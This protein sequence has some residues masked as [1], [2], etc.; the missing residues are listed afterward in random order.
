[1]VQPSDISGYFDILGGM[2]G[3]SIFQGIEYFLLIVLIFGGFA[4]VYYYISFPFKVTVF[5]LYVAGRMVCLV[6]AGLGRIG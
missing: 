4:V 2:F 5:P 3:G 1:M 6:L